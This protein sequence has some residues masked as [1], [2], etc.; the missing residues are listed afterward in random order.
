MAK[1]AKQ[2]AKKTSPVV[3]AGIVA[4]AVAV[5]IVT[6]PSDDAAATTSKR[7]KKT[8]ASKNDGVITQ[9]DL[10]AYK[11]K[12]PPVVVQAV[13]AFN[14]LVKKQIKAA[15]IVPLEPSVEELEARTRAVPVSLTNGEQ[16]WYVTGCPSLNGVREA[17]LENTGTGE[18]KY[19]R[20][21]DRWK[22]A[23]VQGV[24]LSTL[25]LVASNGTAVDVPILQPGETPGGDK[26][27]D[28]PTN[29]PLPIP[30]S[31]IS[32][33]IGNGRSAG[34]PTTLTLSDGRTIQLP[35]PAASEQTAP[36]AAPRR[37]RNRNN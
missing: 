1:A 4:A 12:F 26:K 14:P 33:T 29:A 6:T 35:L 19:V 22:A 8:V 27:K 21:G 28:V 37:R 11:R 24:D 5:Y 32:G 13:D 17:L 15:A 9:A 10:D 16:N 2:P 23:R 25:T 34:G 7:K 36:A 31:A 30:G 20:P 3:W 18:L